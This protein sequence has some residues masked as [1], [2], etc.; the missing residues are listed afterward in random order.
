[1]A[2]TRLIKETVK[3][4]IK[5]VTN[6]T[7]YIYESQVLRELNGEVILPEYSSIRLNT[8]ECKPIH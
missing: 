5:W 1:M 8:K 3:Y 7:L 4:I 2:N 6:N